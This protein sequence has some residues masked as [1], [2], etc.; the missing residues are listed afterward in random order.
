MKARTF[1]VVSLLLLV[2]VPGSWAEMAV[3]SDG[4]LAEIT[5]TGFPW[6]SFYLEDDLDAAGTASITM[7]LHIGVNTY[8]EI[9]SVKLGYY[10]I[11]EDIS[12][13]V[14]GWDQNWTGVSVGSSGQDMAL[15]DLFIDA[16]YSEGQLSSVSIGCKH[17]T[18]ALSGNF[19]S[20]SV[21][22][23]ATGVADMRLSPGLQ[24]LSL[25]NNPL[26]L[27]LQAARGDQP[28]GVLLDIGDAYDQLV[29]IEAIDLIDSRSGQ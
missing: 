27:T 7:G 14:P 6:A 15:R 3:L 13:T 19:E 1:L 10:E 25:N 26:I 5:A 20:L 21:V 22:N 24:T 17:A 28:A 9:D 29:V 2:W 23:P 4:E 16:K 11:A 18:G 8:T 12:P